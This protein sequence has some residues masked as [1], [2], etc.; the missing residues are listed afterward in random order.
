MSQLIFIC[1]A[2]PC[3][4]QRTAVSASATKSRV[5]AKGVVLCETT[6]FCLLSAFYKTLPSKNPSKNLDFTDNPCRCLTRFFGYLFSQGSPLSDGAEVRCC[7][8][9]E[10]SATLLEPESAFCCSSLPTLLLGCWRDSWTY[11]A[12]EADL[13][14][15]MPRNPP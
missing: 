4:L 7:L 12:F 9:R 10:L 11:H 8:L 2:A 1:Y 3:K 6:C 14:K 5:H 13:G 15:G